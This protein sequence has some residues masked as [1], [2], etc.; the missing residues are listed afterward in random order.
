MVLAGSGNPTPTVVPRTW[1]WIEMAMG[2]SGN[3][4]PTS[5]L[6][7]FAWYDAHPI[8]CYY[9]YTFYIYRFTW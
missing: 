1:T 8:I 2:G 3:P 7:I 6:L 9:V 4:T 5:R